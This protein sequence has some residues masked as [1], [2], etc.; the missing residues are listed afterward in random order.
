MC[1]P[2]SVSVSFP[3]PSIHTSASTGPSARS[4]SEDSRAPGPQ[5]HRQRRPSWGHCRV[6]PASAPGAI[7]WEFRWWQ[8]DGESLTG[9]VGRCCREADARSSLQTFGDQPPDRTSA[10]LIRDANDALTGEPV[11]AR[12]TW[13]VRRLRDPRRSSGKRRP[14]WGHCR[15]APAS[16]PAATYW[17]V[18]R[19]PDG[20]PLTGDGGRCCHEAGAPVQRR[21]LLQRT[22]RSNLTARLIRDANEVQPPCAPW[23]RAAIRTRRASRSAASWSAG[24]AEPLVRLER[25]VA[26]RDSSDRGQRDRPAIRPTPR[27]PCGK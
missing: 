11:T 6:A 4:T 9:D 10:R 19:L 14:S 15:V 1:H 12:R 21:N 16:A 7:K 24:D 22:L 27:V 20:E 25:V 23:A 26:E 8:P 2:T 13:L 5:R 17:S 18:D 3:T